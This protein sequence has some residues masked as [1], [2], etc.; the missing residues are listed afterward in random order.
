MEDG[1]VKYTDLQTDMPRPTHDGEFLSYAFYFSRTSASISQWYTF[2]PFRIQ[3][4]CTRAD[5][6]NQDKCFGGQDEQTSWC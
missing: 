1:C 5:T 4:L 2:E 6:I 3:H